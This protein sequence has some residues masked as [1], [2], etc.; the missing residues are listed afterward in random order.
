LRIGGLGLLGGQK[1]PDL[2]R[3]RSEAKS[4]GRSLKECSIV[5]MSAPEGVPSITGEVKT[6]LP[7]VCI[8]F[9]SVPAMLTDFTSDTVSAAGRPVEVYG[10]LP[11]QCVWG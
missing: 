9:C 4:E 10:G 5:L 6:V 2:L 11:L 1:R 3:A 8:V 7:N